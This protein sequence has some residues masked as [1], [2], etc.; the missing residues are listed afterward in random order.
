MTEAPLDLRPDYPVVGRPIP[1]HIQ[2]TLDL[3]TIDPPSPT[4]IAGKQF[5]QIGNA[6]PPPLAYAILHTLQ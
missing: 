6:V 1:Q 5:E 3:D 2:M 4:E